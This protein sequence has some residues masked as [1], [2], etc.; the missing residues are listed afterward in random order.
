MGY[1]SDIEIAQEADI[2]P[3]VEIASNAGV[4]EK[5]LEYYG[6][7]KAKFSY[8]I[9][10]DVA[11][12]E[13]GKLILDV[14]QNNEVHFSSSFSCPDCGVSIDEIE[15]DDSFWLDTH[16]LRRS[17]MQYSRLKL[18]KRLDNYKL[19]LPFLNMHGLKNAPQRAK[20]LEGELLA[21]IESQE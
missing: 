9:Y 20:K 3:I 8:D 11:D 14:D 21:Y 2:R 18:V 17:D 19:K 6:K 15:Q 12:K 4:D 10:D 7:Y 16:D 13:D 1:K 5:Y